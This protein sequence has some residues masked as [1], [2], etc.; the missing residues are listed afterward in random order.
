[1][2]YEDLH[3]LLESHGDGGNDDALEHGLGLEKCADGNKLQLEDVPCCLLLQVREM[4]GETA[5]LKQRL[6]LDFE[7]FELDKFMVGWEVAEIGE[8][9]TGLLLSA[10]MEEPSGREGHPDHADEEDDGGNDLNANRDKPGSIGLGFDGGS[11][12]V[13][14]TTEGGECVAW[15]MRA[16]GCFRSTH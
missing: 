6:G 8:D 3:S 11:T 7:E 14:A 15:Q 1:M 5:L 2:V 4:L 10:V 13:V 12:D 9:G 16:P